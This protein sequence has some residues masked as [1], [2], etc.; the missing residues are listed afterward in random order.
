MPQGFCHYCHASPPTNHS[1][2]STLWVLVRVV[3]THTEPEHYSQPGKQ[4]VLW[5]TYNPR[6]EAFLRTTASPR[7]IRRELST[8]EQIIK[9]Q[10]RKIYPLNIH[11]ITNFASKYESREYMASDK[12]SKNI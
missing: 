1:H 12:A 3:Q 8:E 2:R 5:S 9:P 4:R 6:S 11:G 7:I 10:I